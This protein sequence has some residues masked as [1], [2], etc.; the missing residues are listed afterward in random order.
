M[1]GC[2]PY[3]FF[4]K[5]ADF[6]F[7]LFPWS[8]FAHWRIWENIL[9]CVFQLNVLI[10]PVAVLRTWM[11]SLM[12]RIKVIDICWWRCLLVWTPLVI[13]VALREYKGR[14][15]NTVIWPVMR[16]LFT[17]T[18]LWSSNFTEDTASSLAG[19]KG[20]KQV[21][22]PRGRLILEPVNMELTNKW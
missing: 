2:I 4:I 13:Y 5:L 20:T 8:E 18:L 1:E 16:P 3:N 12:S 11:V 6:V 15:S 22:Y 14:N 21:L 19:T 10:I 9:C 17:P 7:Y